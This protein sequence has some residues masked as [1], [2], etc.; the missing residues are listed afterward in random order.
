MTRSNPKSD[1]PGAAC[2]TA[3]RFLLVIVPFAMLFGVVATEAG[4]NVA[5]VMG[6]SVLVIAGAAQFAALQQMV[7]ADT[8]IAMIL[9]TALAV[10]LRMAMYSASLTPW[11]GQ[12][13]LWKRALVAYLMVD[14]V[15]LLSVVEIRD[16]TRAERA[17]AGTLLLR[18]DDPHCAR[19]G[20]A[21][22]LPAP[23]SGSRSRRSSRSISPCR[24]PF[25][26]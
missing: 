8:P 12:A 17:R 10:N 11:L 6:M 9:L 23:W 24:S 25:S 19:P 21:R 1:H 5:E 22:P 4:L 2:S 20:T 13:R 3:R 26:R 15:Y 14:Q 16:R 18:R 7:D